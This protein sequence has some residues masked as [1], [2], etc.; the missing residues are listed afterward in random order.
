MAQRYGIKGTIGENRE[1]LNARKLPPTGDPLRIAYN[2]ALEMFADA[3]DNTPI[4]PSTLRSEAIL[5]TQSQVN[6]N[7]LAGKANSSGGG[8]TVRSSEKRLELQDCFL[9]TEIAV[10][11]GNELTAGVVPGAVM[12]QTFENPAAVAVLPLTVGGFGANAP[13]LIEAYNGTLDMIVDTVQ[14]LNGLD[15]LHFKRVDQAQA[16]T[17]LFTASTQ[18]QSFFSQDCWFP[19]APFVNLTGRSSCQFTLN[20]PDSTAFNLVASNRVI[21]VLVLRGLKVANGAAYL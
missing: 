13:S 18:A 3:P 11:F 5:G 19:I 9:V 21:A 2:A 20:L 16:G 14:Y 8:N 4:L 1:V 17:L 15:M 6:W 12:L 10:M 7:I